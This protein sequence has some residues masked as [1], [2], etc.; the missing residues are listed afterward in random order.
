MPTAM[1]AAWPYP[2][3]ADVVLAVHFGVVLFVIGGLVAVFVGNRLAAWPWV[4]ALWFRMAHLVAIGVV[5][6][7]SW[8]GM[9]CPLTTL[10]VWL[11]EQAGEASHDQSFVA[12]WL[13]R[14]MFFTAPEWVF[15]V[16]YTAFGLLVVLAWWRY[17]PRRAARSRG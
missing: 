10:E 4:N 2:L 14:L 16:A 11:R 6:A 15:A 1:S 8:F 13:Q 9:V 7:Q 3:L 5:V 17:P 12:Y